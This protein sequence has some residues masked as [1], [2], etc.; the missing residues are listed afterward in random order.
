MKLKEIERVLY[1]ENFIVIE[2][3]LTVYKKIN[4]LMSKNKGK[5]KKK[6]TSCSILK[7]NI[8]FYIYI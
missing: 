4:F 2:P 5:D 6:Q 1:F 7:K 3:G 8:S